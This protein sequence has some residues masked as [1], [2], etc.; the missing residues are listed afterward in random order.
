MHRTH[1]G[2]PALRRSAIT[3]TLVA[4][5]A[6]AAL[7]TGAHGA[8][9]A[10]AAA[11]A[12]VTVR[13]EGTSKTLLPPTSVTLGSAAVDKDGVAADACKGSSAAGALQLAS[14][15]D[16]NGSF[17]KSLGG[18]LVSSIDGLTFPSTGARY[19]AFWIND[20]P[21]SQGVC[22]ITPASG[23]SI[24][25]F[26]D[27]YGKKCPPNDGVLGVKAPATA[28]AGHPVTV[29]VTAYSESKGTPTQ[30]AGA[31]VSGD[32]VSAKTSAGGTARL[33]FTK[34]GRFL[35]Q[36]RAPHTVRTETRVSVQT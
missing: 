23:D 20:A 35:L 9:A 1:P 3:C 33:T 10:H 11:G 24:L 13:I 15:G 26:P 14:R 8:P 29:T 30:K 7:T 19:W 36:V 28:R 34:P 18:Y 21:A 12:T 25:F 22:G 6:T 17:S 2:R 27:C 31:T 32:G 5:L 4:L 16:W